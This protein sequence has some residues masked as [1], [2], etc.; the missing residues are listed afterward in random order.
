MKD[1]TRSISRE[2]QNQGGEKE[3]KRIPITKASSQSEYNLKLT[4]Y[5]ESVTI[6]IKELPTKKGEKR[7]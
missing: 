5:P 2:G 4:S 3:K 1:P 7:P 6:A